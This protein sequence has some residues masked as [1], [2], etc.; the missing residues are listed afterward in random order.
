[1]AASKRMLAGWGFVT[2]ALT[3]A[4]AVWSLTDAARTADAQQATSVS[5]G[6]FFFQPQSVNVAVG[7]TV[8]WTNNGQAPHTVTSDTGAFD[9]GRLNNGQTFQQTFSQP[10]TF[11]YHCEIHPSMVGTVVVAAAQQQTPTA[12]AAPQ[13]QTPTVTA[14]APRA[15]GAG[16]AAADE[17]IS[18]LIYAVMAVG[19]LIVIGGGVV[20]VQRV[21]NR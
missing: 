13:Q 3:L 10:G 21:R 2:L 17:D 7:T 12:T 15:G 5:I 14:A 4:L 16:L 6:D 18:P 1:M 20:A 9:S 8:T 11:A 19:A